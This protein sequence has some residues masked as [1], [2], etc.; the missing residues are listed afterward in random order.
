[1]LKH[2]ILIVAFLC[3]I[4]SNFAQDKSF[5]KQTAIIAKSIDSITSA[6]KSAMKKSLEKIEKKIE[7][8]AISS[9]E[10]QAEKS[11]IAQYHAQKINEGV[12]IQEE[13][14]QKIIQ[15]KVNGT[16]KSEEEK[17]WKD[18]T[19]LGNDDENYQRDSITGLKIEK[20]FTSQFVII[21]GANQSVTETGNYYGDGFK[22]SPFGYGEV[23]FSF[24]YRLKEASSLWNFKIGF[25]VVAMELKPNNE[26][27]VFVMDNGKTTLQDAGFPIKKSRL[28]V[29]YLTIPMH[30]EIDLSKPKYDR[31]SNQSYLR[32][33]TG[34]RM[35][36]GGFLGVRYYS[37]QVVKYNDDGKK[38]RKVERDDFNVN[39]FTFGP[40][41]YIGYRDI[42]L[43][44]RYDVNPVFKNNPTD[45]NNLSFG[46]RFDFN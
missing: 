11:E 9:D 5:E 25:S 1:M 38:I 4:Q 10:A 43:F 41:A 36:V 18:Y 24:K 31:Y 42:S 26:N 44:A 39:S 27:V 33:Q 30:L 29:G 28:S 23:G 22:V 8:E 2:G 37:N 32:S 19:F 35:G 14:L 12:R 34:F 21:L 20:R 6:E 17:N 40:S 15:D 13:R 3:L 46:L 45:I 7:K 16:L